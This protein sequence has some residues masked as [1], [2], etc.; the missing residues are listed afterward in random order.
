[1]GSS[2]EQRFMGVLWV[3][4]LL[5]VCFP[6]R[7]GGRHEGECCQE[8]QV[9]KPRSTRKDSDLMILSDLIQWKWA[10]RLNTIAAGG[11]SWMED[12]WNLLSNVAYHFHLTYHQENFP[13]LE[14]RVHMQLFMQVL[15]LPLLFI[16]PFIHFLFL[17]PLSEVFPSSSIHP[18]NQTLQSINGWS[19]SH[20]HGQVWG[21]VLAFI[22]GYP[23][24]WVF[25]SNRPIWFLCDTKLH[26]TGLVR[27]QSGQTIVMLNVSHMWNNNFTKTMDSA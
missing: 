13:A 7:S 6:G 25:I 24:P 1:M 15:L 20:I 26:I 27:N 12:R 2:R 11:R 22:L 19:R 18:L 8:R 10:P 5:S 4:G 3:S 14:K 17:S 16:H 21:L 9:G 23:P